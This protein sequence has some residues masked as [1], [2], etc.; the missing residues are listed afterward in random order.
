FFIDSY[1]C[2]TTDSFLSTDFIILYPHLEAKGIKLVFLQ[3]ML[4]TLYSE[5]TPPLN[6]DLLPENQKTVKKAWKRLFWQRK[7]QRFK[8]KIKYLGKDDLSMVRQK[9]GEN[10]IPQKYKIITNT[11]FRI[12]FANIP[13]WI[14]APAE[15]EFFPERKAAW[16]T[17]L[18]SMI[19]LNRKEF[20]DEKYADFEEQI[21]DFKNSG[22]KLIYCSFGTL[23]HLNA[24]GTIQFFRNILQAVKDS[25]NYILICSGT[26]DIQKQIQALPKN[27]YWFK[28]VPQLRLLAEVDVFVTHEG[29]N[30]IKESLY[31]CVPM[32]I[33]PM[34]S[35]TDNI[36]NAARIFHHRLGLRGEIDSDSPQDI[37]AKISEL[38]T[39]PIYRQNLHEFKEKTAANYTEERVLKLLE[40]VL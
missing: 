35:S 22:K 8:D 14:L 32:L 30:S 10:K 3:T 38:L 31:F 25:P 29:L 1:R 9:F 15:L 36:G 4:S 37:A 19:D 6:A 13:E 12:S 18:G 26:E 28:F 5:G 20:G 17:Y 16:Q 39:N 11:S 27:T 34:Y 24:E 40:E 21:Q 23:T 7:V 2:N 33:Y